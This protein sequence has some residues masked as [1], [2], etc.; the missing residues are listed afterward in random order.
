MIL[1]SFRLGMLW[2]N[3][4]SLLNRQCT[5]MWQVVT[6]LRL[7][8]TFQSW[9]NQSWKVFP[10]VKISSFQH[11]FLF[12]FYQPLGHKFLSQSPF[13]IHVFWS[14]VFI[15]S[16]IFRKDLRVKGFY[17]TP[18]QRFF[19]FTTLIMRFVHWILWNMLQ[20]PILI[21]ACCLMKVMKKIVLV[22][23]ASYISSKHCIWN[24][25]I[26]CLFW[27]EHIKIAWRSS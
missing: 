4:R 13:I 24:H 6:T 18:M 5:C 22:C 19:A 17:N 1:P 10:S 23:Y 21:F 11:F 14:D 20:Q 8:F 27:H 15:S 16:F 7:V 26:F 2:S 9:T 25:I 3:F 12:S